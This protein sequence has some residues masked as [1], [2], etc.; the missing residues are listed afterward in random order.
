MGSS[1][2]FPGPISNPNGQTPLSLCMACFQSWLGH[3]RTLYFHS[4]ATRFWSKTRLLESS[5]TY[6]SSGLGSQ[7]LVGTKNGILLHHLN[8][9]C[10]RGAS[11]TIDSGA[12]HPQK[13]T[14][15]N[16]AGVTVDGLDDFGWLDALDGTGARLCCW[17]SRSTGRGCATFGG[18]ETLAV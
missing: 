15:R 5:I 10:F 11:R 16:T 2:Y 14:Q 1:P 17:R 4:H 12:E 6:S 8:P 13:V 9:L 7:E 18:R 3:R